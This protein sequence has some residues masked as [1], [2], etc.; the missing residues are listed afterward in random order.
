MAEGGSLRSAPSPRSGRAHHLPLAVVVATRGR[1]ARLRLA[2]RSVGAQTSGPREVVVVND[3]GPAADTDPV[4]LAEAAAGVR[5]RVVALPRPLGQA[6]ARAL[7][8]DVAD[9]PALAFLDDDDLW[10]PDH[11]Q[12]LWRALEGGADLAYSDA[13]VVTIDRAAYPER[14]VERRLFALAWDPAFARRYNP[15]I[16]SGV[17]FR[18]ALLDQAGP[19][20]P[21]AGHHWDWDFLLR[22][23][24]AGARV[25]RVARAT[26]LYTVD[27]A[28][29]NESARTAEMVASVGRLA[30]SHGLGALAPHTFRTMLDLPEVR[31]RLAPS[32]RPWDGGWPPEAIA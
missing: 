24:G 30:G 29:D 17:A 2:L 32:E 25:A 10:L 23:V 4:A 19:I 20:R 27:A 22:A 9:A 5:V 28:G 14:V 18:R 8:V 1:P 15:V 7:G 21:E 11:L 16:P 13:E 31:D 12:G 26:L 3:G 6:A